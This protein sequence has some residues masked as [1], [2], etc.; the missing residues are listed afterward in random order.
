MDAIARTVAVY[1][2]LLVI[3]RV[4]GRRTL[5]EASNFDFVLLLIVAEATQQALLGDD[6]SVTNSLLIITTLFL[7]D[8]TATWLKT[9]WER[10]D[11]LI[12]GL[13]V[14]L[15]ERGE[16]LHDNLE[17]HRVNVNDIME[18]ARRASGLRSLSDIDYAVLE[19]SGDIAIIPR[20][21]ESA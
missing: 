12:D 21:P 13:P 20:A 17:D 19:R 10:F 9:R 1:L 11:R 14:V 4:A 7:V 8:V 18:E 2:F 15:I 5:A 3:F 16:I 6:F